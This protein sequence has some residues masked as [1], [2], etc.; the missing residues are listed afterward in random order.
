[1]VSGMAVEFKVIPAHRV[2]AVPLLLKR[3]MPHSED[4]SAD[5]HKAEAR[6]ARRESSCCPGPI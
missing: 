1:M 4:F 2:K 6:L 3:N 5:Q